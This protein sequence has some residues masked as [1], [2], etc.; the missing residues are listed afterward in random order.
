MEQLKILKDSS[1]NSKYQSTFLPI[2]QKAETDIKKLILGAFLVLSSKN[3]LL[4]KIQGIVKRVE[5]DLP[6]DLKDR[7]QYIKAIQYKANVLVQDYYDK[8]KTEFLSIAAL[9]ALNTP[10]T[11]PQART[12]VKT[13]TIETPKQLVR[14]LANPTEKKKLNLDMWTEAKGAVRVEK[15]QAKVNQYIKALP[16]IPMTTLT[17][18][19]TGHSI[20]LWQKAEIDIRQQNQ[21]EMLGKAINSGQEL[22]W[23]SSHPNCSKRCEKWQGKLVSVTEH[24]KMSG[25]R[26]RKEGNEWVYSLPDI[27]AQVQY[28][29]KEHTPYTNNIIV[30]FNCRH[31]LIPYKPGQKPTQE[32]SEQQVKR[33]REIETR[34]REMEREIR[35][36]K[37]E[38]QYE[39]EV[40]GETPKSKQM[41][42]E[43]DRDVHIYKRYCEKNGYA[44]YQY[45]ITI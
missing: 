42:A 9:I 37:Q 38:Y 4:L 41:L 18:T 44:W 45:R 23:I 19:N 10:K 35:E 2:L 3:T 12:R 29:K 21:L 33:Q 32:Y 22:W 16:R 34:I 15:Y 20:T 30:G 6:K 5:K 31:H 39:L 43:I 1:T 40:Y 26:V 36:L 17:Y 25:M 8:P 27:T 14:M 11:K 24:A 7:E 13:P 28:T